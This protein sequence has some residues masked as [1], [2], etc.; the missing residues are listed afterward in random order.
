MKSRRFNCEYGVFQIRISDTI[1]RAQL[2]AL[3]DV[4]QEQWADGGA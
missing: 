2:Q 3:M 4:V 1:F